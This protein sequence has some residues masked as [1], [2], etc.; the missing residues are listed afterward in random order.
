[1]S[2][3]RIVASSGADAVLLRV[4]VQI[5]AWGR[6][7]AD[8]DAQDE[9]ALDV[10]DI[11]QISVADAT[12][13]GAVVSGGVTRRGRAAYRVVAG[14]G[15]WGDSVDATAYADDNG[16]KRSAVI[17]D[18]ANAVGETVSGAPDTRVGAHY[19]R[20]AGSASRVL[21][22]LAP[23]AWYVGLDGVTYFGE[24]ASTTYDGD[25]PRTAQHPAA[26]T[27]ELALREGLPAFVPGIVVDGLTPASDVDWH[28][29]DRKLRVVVHAAPQ[30]SRELDAFRRIFD[31]M[32]PRRAYRAVYE[33]RV[34]TQDGDAL[35]LQPVRASSGM[36][37]LERVPVRLAPGV[38]ADHALGSLV[39]VVFV[40]GDPSRPC[41][42][43]GDEAG[44]PGW[45]PTTLTLGETPTLGVA[46]V[47]DPV[48]AGPWAGT[49]TSASAR[50]KAG[51]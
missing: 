13:V 41:V 20:S 27:I 33:Y 22:E 51:L 50:I 11:V 12:L 49:I 3:A 46:R 16:V 31:A 30:A 15:G 2:T 17:T 32:D 44:A 29:A 35:N 38:E 45:M 21:H 23:R 6:W 28:L 43:S 47:T 39:L 37:D 25:A 4:R 10:G 18:A 48:L 40:D 36:P 9:I 5:P 14:A 7:W 24:R 1:M 26:G 8:V 42:I 19:A 34:V